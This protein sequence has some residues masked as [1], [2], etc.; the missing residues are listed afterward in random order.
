MSAT[1]PLHPVRPPLL[2]RLRLRRDLR[3]LLGE[4]DREALEAIRRRC[5]DDWPSARHSKYWQLERQLAKN[6]RRAYRLG[7]DRAR[8]RAEVLDLG[9]GFGYFARV[10]DF[11]G[12]R[13][14]ALDLDDSDAGPPGSLYDAVT[15]VLGVERHLWTIQPF[16]PLPDTGRRYDLVTAFAAL[17]NEP[18]GERAWGAAEW[19]YFLDDL[20]GRVLTPGGRAFLSLNRDR[21]GRYLDPE[22]EAL[23]RAAGGEVDGRDVY[24]PR[25]GPGAGEG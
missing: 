10:C 23:F 4:L 5:R 24:F 25:L 20:T 16:Q 17:F 13:A 2:D 15:R 8:R 18:A 11:Y 6:L 21:E 12:H 3:R 9:A 14:L 22:V 7:L 1:L 19:R